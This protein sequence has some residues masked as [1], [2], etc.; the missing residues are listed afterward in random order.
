MAT[1]VTKLGRPK[2]TEPL[3]R[4]ELKAA[5]KEAKA[6]HAAV[7]KQ[8]QA[9]ARLFSEQVEAESKIE[10]LQ[11]A[12]KKAEQAHIQA[13]AD[14]AVAGSPPPVSGLPEALASLAFAQDR[15]HTLRA[16]RKVIEEEIPGWEEDAAAADTEVERLISQVIADYVEVLVL[17]ATELA[18]RL[19]PYRAALMAFARDHSDR[20]T[21]WHKQTAFDKARSPLD[22]AANDVW[23]FFRGVREADPPPVNPWKSVRE[24]LRQNPNGA[25]LRHLVAEFDGLCALPDE[26]P[27]GEPAAPT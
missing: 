26:Q 17:E 11:K 13:V 20:P 4:S 27:R 16:A 7:G 8:K 1:G 12:V 21:E 18:K 2:A 23:L 22:E 19:Q 3:P 15:V 24:G 9:K 25:V 5:I 6:A 10:A 14:A